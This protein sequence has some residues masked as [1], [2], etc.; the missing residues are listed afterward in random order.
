VA[1]TVQLADIGKWPLKVVHQYH[2]GIVDTMRVSV[3]TYGPAIIQAVIDGVRPHPPVNTGDY[4][5]GWKVRNITDG[6]FLYNPTKQAGIIERGRRP[7]T[8]VSQEGQEAIAR[9][10]HLH[11]MDR[12]GMSTRERRARRKMRAAGAEKAAFRFRTRWTQDSRA[13]AIAFLIARAIKRRGLPAKNILAQAKP[14]LTM[15]VSNDVEAMIA[16]G[17]QT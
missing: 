7:G 5:R 11:G 8:G 3:K 2:S 14:I 16:R 12:D 15:Q 13:R 6:V 4:R 10:V 17:P 1:S 9:W